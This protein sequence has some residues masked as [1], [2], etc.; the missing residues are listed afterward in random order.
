MQRLLFQ[1]LVKWKKKPNRKPLI[2]EGARQTGK[3]WLLKELGRREYKETHYLLFDNNPILKRVFSNPSDVPGIMRMLAAIL[4]STGKPEETLFIFDEI[5][6]CPEAMTSL[7]YF[8]ENAPE[9]NIV[10][11]G[12]LLG[13]AEH[14]GYA[15]PVGKVDFLTLYPMTFKEFLMAMD[16]DIIIKALEDHDHDLLDILKDEC[17]FLLRQYMYVGGM[18][19]A[20]QAFATSNGNDY[21]EVR[22]I[23]K[24]ILRS[25]ENDFSK[26]ISDETELKR[27]ETVWSAIPKQ[28][29]KE[30]KKF[31]FSALQG[32]RRAVD[33]E[34]ALG[35]LT[36]AGLIYMEKRLRTQRIPTSA[37]EDDSIFKIY[38]LDIGLLAAQSRLRHESIISD[39]DVLI[40]FK[41]A[42]A[43]QYAY[44]ELIQQEGLNLHY[45]TNDNST[46]EV[47]FIIDDGLSI[48]PLD[49]KSGTNVHAKSLKAY[50]A[51]YIPKLALRASMRG[52][53]EQDGLIS[54][55]LYELSDVSRIIRERL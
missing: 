50:M 55:P 20:V 43:E 21:A 35:W 5:Q 16:K 15:F 51:R 11:A 3:T 9:Y 10:A 18:P 45:Y 49:I 34:K 37:Y 38:M 14:T 22:R 53:E 42:L 29:A 1:E 39:T 19:E 36:K 6:E 26:H 25:Y 41:G 40:E 46:G 8:Q 30:N 13:I 4:G 44:Q 23:Q 7:K 32:S 28:L 54:L 27:V 12:S 24:S 48:V 47:E 52:Y 33:Y 31:I 17:G 2:I